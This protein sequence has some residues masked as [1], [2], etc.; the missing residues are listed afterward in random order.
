[1]LTIY[2]SAAQQLQGSRNL[3][4]IATEYIGEHGLRFNPNK[5]TCMIMGGNPFTIMPTW[6][7]QDVPLRIVD[8][9]KGQMT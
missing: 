4:N 2:F 5:T 9:I 6:K 8:T 7:I 3:I 1:M